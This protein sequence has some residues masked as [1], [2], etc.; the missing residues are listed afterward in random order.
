MEPTVRVGIPTAN[1]LT[2][3][4]HL[5]Q[6]KADVHSFEFLYDLLSQQSI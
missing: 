5:F 1:K 6:P 3:S 2:E 4:G